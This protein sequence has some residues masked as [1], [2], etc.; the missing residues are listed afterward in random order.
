MKQKIIKAII[1]TAIMIAVSFLSISPINADQTVDPPFW[2]G[3]VTLYYDS[4]IMVTAQNSGDIYEISGTSVAAALDKASEEG[5]FTYTILD[6]WYDSFGL[7]IDSIDGTENQGMDGWQYW[8]NFPEDPIPMIS[9][10]KYQLSDNDTVYWFFGGYPA[11]PLNTTKLI[12]IH[13][14]II[15]DSIEPEVTLTK[16][17]KGGVYINNNQIFAFPFQTAFVLGDLTVKASAYDEQTSIDK[18][19]FYIDG[20]LKHSCD[21]KPYTFPFTED[22]KGKFSLKV[23]AYDQADNQ[24]EIEMVILRIPL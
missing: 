1:V 5:E 23:T 2:Q 21:E 24:K 17:Q 7:L 15:E 14:N 10:D 20:V 18:I 4:T 12:E 22:I 8:V 11:D 6:T 16:P 3:E 9:A 13:V 19:E